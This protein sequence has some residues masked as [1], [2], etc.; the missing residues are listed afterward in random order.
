MEAGMVCRSLHSKVSNFQKVAIQFL[1]DQPCWKFAYLFILMCSFSW[2]G[3]LLSLVIPFTPESDQCQISIPAPPEI[4]HQE[5]LAFHSFLRW[6]MIIIQILA[7]SFMHF[8]FKMLAEFTF[9]AQEWKVQTSE[10]PKCPTSFQVAGRILK[11]RILTRLAEI[12][13]TRAKIRDG[14]HKKRKSIRGTSQKFWNPRFSEVQY[15][16]VPG[17]GKKKAWFRNIVVKSRP[18]ESNANSLSF[19]SARQS[20]TSPRI[21]MQKLVFQYQVLTSRK[22]GFRPYTRCRCSESVMLRP[23]E[24]YGIRSNDKKWRSEE[25]WQAL[26]RDNCW[27]QVKV[28]ASQT[29]CWQQLA[30]HQQSWGRHQPS[31]VEIPNLC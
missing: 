20:K 8:L 12:A 9:W 4:L 3:S 6:K 28:F 13:D 16:T 25:F 24:D 23:A 10:T 7:S 26:S 22:R 11:W 1:T 31:T 27:F 5:N 30:T 17:K 19:P 21:L 2:W 18:V 15:T 29:T 14:T